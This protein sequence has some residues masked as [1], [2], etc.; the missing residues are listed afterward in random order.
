M[1][2]LKISHDTWSCAWPQSSPR[3]CYC[4]WVTVLS[5]S[6]GNGVESC[7]QQTVIIGLLKSQTAFCPHTSADTYICGQ[8]VLPT[9]T[10]HFHPRP[11]K[12]TYCFSYQSFFLS[13]CFFLIPSLCFWSFSVQQCPSRHEDPACEPDSIDGELGTPSDHLPPTHHQLHGLLQ[14]GET[15]CC[16]W[17]DLHQDWG[18]EHGEYF[19]QLFI[20]DQWPLPRL[21]RPSS[22]FWIYG[23][24]LFFNNG[25]TVF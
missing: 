25:Y 6:S 17:K 4:Y 23:F 7:Q 18:P 9:T 20:Q 1:P 15:W 10:F 5:F 19:H 14:L 12:C 13:C 22:F 11:G 21:S 24:F 2:R 3:E 16:R 8:A